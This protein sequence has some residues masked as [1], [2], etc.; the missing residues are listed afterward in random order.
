MRTRHASGPGCTRVGRRI[1]FRPAE[2]DRLR[3]AI[4]AVLRRAIESPR[5]VP[6]ATTSAAPGLRG[7]FQ[8]EFAV[9]GRTG[10][11]CPVCKTAIKS[12]RLA[13]RS[14]HFCPGVSRKK[15]GVHRPGQRD[16]RSRGDS[17]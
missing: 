6:S 2:C 12:V 14:S 13:G 7:G 15:P 5:L 16:G 10:E 9:Y 3:V 8:N 17:V 1:R 4:E 11:P